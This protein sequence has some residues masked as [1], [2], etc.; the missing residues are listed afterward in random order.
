MQNLWVGVDVYIEVSSYD[1]F[2]WRWNE[3]F[4]QRRKFLEKC[5]HT[6]GKWTVYCWWKWFVCSHAIKKT[7]P[8]K[9]SYF[10][11]C[12]ALEVFYYMWRD[13]EKLKAPSKLTFSDLSNLT[14]LSKVIERMVN[15]QLTDFLESHKLLPKFQSGTVP[16]IKPK[17]QCSRSWQTY[18]RPRIAEGCYQSLKS[19]VI[20]LVKLATKRRRDSRKRCFIRSQRIL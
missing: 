2:G 7:R 9:I 1:D 20:K 15:C 12:I 13:E 3:K 6:R 18:Y 10:P 19:R 5:G 11:L 17:P 16:L 14:I 4:K 8:L